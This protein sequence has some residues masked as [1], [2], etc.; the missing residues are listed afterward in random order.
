M[1]K[2][3]L[4]ILVG[5]CLLLS[6]SA[7]FAAEDGIAAIRVYVTLHADGSADITEIWEINNV[8]K[9]TEYYKALNNVGKNTVS[10]LTVT[11]DRG[12]QYQTLRS[13]NTDASFAE[14]ANKCGIATTDEG[15]ELCWGISEMGDRTYTITYRLA[16]LVKHYSDADG[17]YHRFISDGMTSAPKV[18]EVFITLE[19]MPLSADNCQ[20]WAMGYQGEVQFY[21]KGISAFSNTALRKSNHI[22]LL[23]RFDHGL[24]AAPSG[25]GTFFAIQD[26]ALQPEKYALRAVGGVLAGLA[27]LFAMIGAWVHNKTKYIRLA[28]GIKEQRVKEKDAPLQ[29]QPVFDSIAATDVLTRLGAPFGAAGNPTSAYM[30]RWGMTGVATLEEGSNTLVLHKAPQGEAPEAALYELFSAEAENGRLSLKK[31]HKWMETHRSE[32]AKWQKA[33][34]TYGTQQLEN[35]RLVRYDADNKPLLTAEGLAAYTHSLGYKRYI[36]SSPAED[37]LPQALVF[38]AYYSLTKEMKAVLDRQSGNVYH[39]YMYPTYG[40]YLYATRSGRSFSTPPSD[41]S[42]GS[43]SSGGGGGFSGGGGGGSR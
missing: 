13:W 9:G 1:K 10:N 21:D 5:L 15:Y 41:G 19:G 34:E 26:R 27:A 31:W 8:Y 12:V 18:A 30:I 16:G 17:F 43:A 37:A 11:D 38:A 42:G 7:A 2:T 32:W 22:T 4:I 29:Q 40:Y 6:I 35:A 3:V 14:K 39:D 25:N 23:V 33:L 20:I 36:K 24:F 28:D